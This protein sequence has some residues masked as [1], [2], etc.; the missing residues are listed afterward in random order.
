M[1]KPELE[2]SRM[3]PN[4]IIRLAHEAKG[5][6][7]DAILS[8]I[9]ESEV[10]PSS[11]YEFLAG[12]SQKVRASL[13]RNPKLE[14][15]Y[16]KRLAEDEAPRVRSSLA[17]NP[18]I[19]ADILA[20]LSK[21]A[22]EG[23]RAAVARSEKASAELLAQMAEKPENKG[24]VLASIAGS[25][26]APPALILKIV[27][28]EDASVKSRGRGGENDELFFAD[29]SFE[30]LA[31][32]AAN[33]RTPKEA[34][35]LLAHYRGNEIEWSLAKNPSAP[36]EVLSEIVE[37]GSPSA[38][39]DLALNPAL[40]KQLALKIAELADELGSANLAQKSSDKEVIESAVLAFRDLK[41][42]ERVALAASKNEACPTAALE[43]IFEDFKDG[44]NET[45]LFRLARNPATPTSLL[46][47]LAKCSSAKA[48]KA[49]QS[50]LV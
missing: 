31:R 22:D 1:P 11:L 16:L 46:Q 36:L 28:A 33:E 43:K 3:S 20:R 26:S 47:K 9:A 19:P 25:P 27:K 38:K 42:A 2:L 40:P 37:K 49:A 35:E 44:S 10:C 41:R 13:A 15:S 17:L 45:V 23:V 39:R 7:K 18:S 32:A 24:M 12:K 21:D 50:R 48:A 5:K 30:P 14:G 6:E 34:L 29:E 8:Q 4:E